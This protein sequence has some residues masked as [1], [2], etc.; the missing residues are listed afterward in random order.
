M[1]LRPSHQSN[2]SHPSETSETSGTSG[3]SGT[4]GSVTS[5]RLAA[6]LAAGLRL[7]FARD[8]KEVA[9][10]GVIHRRPPAPSKCP[11]C[12]DPLFGCTGHAADDEFAEGGGDYASCPSGENWTMRKDLETGVS[13]PVV[14]L[15]ACEHAFH[16][17]CIAP[18]VQRRGASPTCPTC[19]QE[20]SPQD[21]DAISDAALELQNE[22][23]RIN[24]LETREEDADGTVYVYR[25]RGER[26]RLV[27]TEFPSGENQ[28]FEGEKDKERKVRVEW[29]GNTWFYEG[30]KN[31]ERKV[32][33]ETR[34]GDKR[35]FEG[36]KGKE[37][38]VRVE[39]SSGTKF[40]FEGE[41][42]KE[43]KVRVEW[44]DGEKLFYEGEK[45]K[46]RKVRVEKADGNKWFFEGEKGKERKVRVKRA[47]D[48]ADADD[49]D[50]DAADDADDARAKRLRTKALAARG[51]LGLERL[52]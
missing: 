7:G 49:G 17:H 52:L 1:S 24:D 31:K 25:G 21:V 16:V 33:E 20:I 43:R 38:K 10:T 35:F 41:K 50:G 3:T 8:Q 28:F 29:D 26:R 11:I 22:I 47:D 19:R 14:T 42:G 30:D 9:M 34:D 45:D 12:G 39:K 48:A 4:P 32:R 46:E 44:I 5:D 27:R 23:V 51:K 6:V 37:R 40:F 18:W 36:D 15:T 2:P 13:L